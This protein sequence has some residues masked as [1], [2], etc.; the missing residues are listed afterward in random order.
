M[1]TFPEKTLVNFTTLLPQ[2]LNLTG[3]WEKALAEIVWPAAIKNITSV[4]FKF[5]VVPEAQKDNNISDS[6]K[7]DTR[8]RKLNARPY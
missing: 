3:F 2:Q 6:S 7:T 4:H 1:V 8:K 5:R